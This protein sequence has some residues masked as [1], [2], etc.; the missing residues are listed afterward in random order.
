MSATIGKMTAANQKEML[1]GL[2]PDKTLLAKHRAEV[3]A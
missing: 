1:A 3:V 2:F